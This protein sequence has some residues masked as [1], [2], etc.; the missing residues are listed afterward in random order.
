MF[1]QIKSTL[2]W[3]CAGLMLLFCFYANGILP[4]DT[5]LL[6]AREK[7]PAS[8][9]WYIGGKIFVFRN[10]AGN[11]VVVET[12]SS[13][14]NVKVTRVQSFRAAAPSRLRF[15]LIREG[16]TVF[17]VTAL[18]GYPVTI[19]PTGLETYRYAAN[20]G[21]QY[22]IVWTVKDGSPVVSGVNRIENPSEAAGAN[23]MLPW[24]TNH[25]SGVLLLASVMMTWKA[26][27]E[28]KGKTLQNQEG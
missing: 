18:V 7:M 19:E 21:T 10:S 3:L 14:G 24:I 15:A 17:Q 20:D 9:T 26:A 2:L 28:R 13:D 25:L 8:G 11:V 4:G 5:T 16:M 27:G 1:S 23:W 12:E 6:E 22:Q